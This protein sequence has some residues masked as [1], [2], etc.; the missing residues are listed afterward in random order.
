M[1]TVAALYVAGALVVLAVV[2]FVGNLF[3]PGAR[4][5]PGPFLAGFTDLF[6]AWNVAKGDNQVSLVKFHEKYGDSVRF[7]PRVV[8]IRNV[9][10]VSRVYSVQ[11]GFPKVRLMCLKAYGRHSRP[12]PFPAIFMRDQFLDSEVLR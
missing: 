10:D 1:M 12:F 2:H 6:R 3:A 5:I 9:I 8:S 4:Q 11:S 7:G